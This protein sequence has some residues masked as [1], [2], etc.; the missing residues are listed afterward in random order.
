MGG[1]RRRQEFRGGEPLVR[2][3]R[4]TYTDTHSSGPSRGPAPMTYDTVITNG[5]VISADGLEKADVA[6]QGEKVAAVGKG[7]AR[8]GAAVVDA[9]GK[10]VLPGA[11]DVHV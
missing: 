5:T 6:L 11:L 8:D 3:P 7:L 4:P 10:Y 1:A 2:P 9:A